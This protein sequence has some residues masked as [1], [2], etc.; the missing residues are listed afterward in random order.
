MLGWNRYQVRLLPGT[1]DAIASYCTCP[2]VDEE[3]GLQV[4]L[5]PDCHRILI[6]GENAYLV[7]CSCPLHGSDPEHVLPEGI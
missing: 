5:E 1:P 7:R 3:S 2:P 4:V 6:H